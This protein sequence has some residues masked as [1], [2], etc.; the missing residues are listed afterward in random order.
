M[1]QLGHP[2]APEAFEFIVASR[3]LQN[4]VPQWYCD[5]VTAARQYERHGGTLTVHP[6]PTGAYQWFNAAL[7]QREILNPADTQGLESLIA[8]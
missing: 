2:E 5:L 7:I 4:Q 8:Q 3:E 6:T 1:R